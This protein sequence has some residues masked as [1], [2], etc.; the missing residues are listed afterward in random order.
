MKKQTQARYKYDACGL[1]NIILLNIP[2]FV[3]AS[4]H[5][6]EFAIP[7]PEKLHKLIAFDLAEQPQKF[8]PEEIRFLKS[9]LGF[10][11]IDFAKAIGVQAETVSRWEHGNANMSTPHEHLLRTLVLCEFGPLHDYFDSLKTLGTLDAT[12]RKKKSYIPKN[13]TWK[14]AA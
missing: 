1:S 3:C 11:G 9:H 12:Q 13:N 10:S 7:H 14:A 2:V 4:C 6:E 5:E 8:L